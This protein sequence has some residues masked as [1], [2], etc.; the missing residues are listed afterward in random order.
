LGPFSPRSIASIVS[1]KPCRRSSSP[2]RDHLALRHAD[3]RDAGLAG[4]FA[5]SLTALASFDLLNGVGQAVAL[6]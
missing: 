4:G 3:S 1:G 6:E 2:S 5:L